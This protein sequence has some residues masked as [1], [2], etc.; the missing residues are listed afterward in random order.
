MV[1][2]VQHV[3]AVCKI[4]NFKNK[5]EELPQLVENNPQGIA[6]RI[7]DPPEILWHVVRLTKYDKEKKEFTAD[8]ESGEKK[9]PLDYV[10]WKSQNY[11]FTCKKE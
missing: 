5:E 1:P 2:C 8:D 11:Y 3:K 4:Q 6:I 10:I 7:S 9:L